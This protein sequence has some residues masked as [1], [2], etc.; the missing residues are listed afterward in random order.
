VKSAVFDAKLRHSWR[1]RAGA[2][3]FVNGAE[4]TA[5]GHRGGRNDS[6]QKLEIYV[7]VI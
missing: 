5:S 6:A 3:Q 1:R 2:L 4:S 7:R